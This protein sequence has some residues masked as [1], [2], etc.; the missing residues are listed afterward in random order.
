MLKGTFSK[1]RAIM[2]RAAEIIGLK[3]AHERNILGQGIGVA[4]LDTGICYHPDFVEKENRIIA[5]EDILHKK[6]SVYDDNGHGTHVASIIGGDGSASNGLYCGV[7]PKCNIISV[8]V[9]NQRGN[10]NIEDVIQGLHWVLENK[11]KYRIRIVNIS[12][13]TTTK[14]EVN[15]DSE[16]VKAVNQVWDRE[17]VVVVAAG[18]GGPR[19]KSIG[20]PGISRK[21][22][23]VG[24]YDDEILVDS[25]G[26]AIKNYSGRG[27]TYSCIKKPDIV[28]PGSNIVACNLVKKEMQSNNF[29]VFSLRTNKSSRTNKENLYIPKSGT[30]MAT[31]QVSGSIA[32]LLSRYPEMSNREVKIRLKNSAVDLGFSH[33]R[34][35]WGLL[36]IENM[37]KNA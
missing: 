8:K 21:V 35:G 11:E 12:V 25:A 7:A 4:V 14:E 20:S 28:A 37:F 36:N 10:G 22:I 18:N 6:N 19:P 5:F 33:E 27:P 16:L 17:I 23:T 32:L 1:R 24:A 2:N 15:E 31:P 13:G 3:W 30:S 26:I 34:Q 29:S 9:L